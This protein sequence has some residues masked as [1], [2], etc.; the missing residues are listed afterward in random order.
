[1]Q[2][3]PAVTEKTQRKI[4]QAFCQLY[5]EKTIDKISIQQ[6][7]NLAGYNRSTFYLYFSDIYAVRQ[8][9]EDDLLN[10]I[11]NS[12]NQEFGVKQ[13]QQ[14]ILSRLMYLFE[15][16]EVELRAVLGDYGN[17]NFLERMKK[18]IISSTYISA[19]FVPGISRDDK[20]FAYILEYNVSS[21]IALFQFW[22]KQG[23]NISKDELVTL[24]YQLYSYGV[25]GLQKL[26]KKLPGS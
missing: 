16:K 25:F 15:D 21:A 13:P 24:T 20:Y 22:L 17:F 10:Y 14:Q 12:M 26:D 4:K 23:K 19:N 8:A 1:M 18:E 5:T 7:M 9:V 11:K 3:Q 2:K 6:I